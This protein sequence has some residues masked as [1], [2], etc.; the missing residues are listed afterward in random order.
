VPILNHGDLCVNW[1][2]GIAQNRQPGFPLLF[3]QKGLKQVVW[4][5]CLKKWLLNGRA[6]SV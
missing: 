1:R 2:S 5:V 6:A 3:E 4:N